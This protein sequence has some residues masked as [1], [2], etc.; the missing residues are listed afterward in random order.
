MNYHLVFGILAGACSVI[1]ISYYVS[2]IFRR[3]TKPNRASWIIWN[4]TNTILLV[5]YFS[6]GARETVILPF[7]YFINGM[8]V[9]PLSFRY[10]VSSWSKLDYATLAV[11]SISLVVW[12]ITNN[13]LV[14]L[15]MN[16]TM[17]ASGYIPTINKSYID[18]ASESMNAWFFIFLGACFNLIAINSASFG[19]VIYPIIMFLMNGILFTVLVYRNRKLI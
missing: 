18:P 8:I 17:D 14:A 12:I 7:V 10:G 2:S 19:V 15:L 6:V 11:A 13:P 9:L 5:S 1:A 4:I 3:E 16:L